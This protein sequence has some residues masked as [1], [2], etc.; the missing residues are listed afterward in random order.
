[1]SILKQ[2]IHY[3]DTNSVEATW[4]DENDVTIKCHSYADVQMQMFRDD[5]ALHGGNIAEHEALITLVEASIKPAA[6]IPVIHV[7]TI[8]KL[9]FVEWCEANGKLDALIALLNSD[10]ILKF[11]WDAATSLSIDN[12]LVIGAAQDLGIADP[13]A[14]FDEIG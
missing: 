13:Q 11:K 5:V 2:V 10:A 6:P 7:S 9:K 3:P 1:M 12:P 4:V 14:V 8:F